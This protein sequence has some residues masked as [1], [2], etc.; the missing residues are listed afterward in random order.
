MCHATAPAGAGLA[1][2]PG[3][4]AAHIGG[5]PCSLTEHWPRP[6]APA[7]GSPTRPV[8]LARRGPPAAGVGGQGRRGAY[9]SLAA[10]AL[11]ARP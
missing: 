2:R 7:L 6:H 10:D 4:R 9:D 1:A 8:S 5:S 11:A 3:L